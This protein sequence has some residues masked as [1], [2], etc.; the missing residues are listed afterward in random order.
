MPA[1]LREKLAERSK[2][3]VVGLYE[4]KKQDSEILSVASQTV[5]GGY[6]CLLAGSSCVVQNVSSLA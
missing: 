2:G 5:R 1:I 3:T 4:S 6:S